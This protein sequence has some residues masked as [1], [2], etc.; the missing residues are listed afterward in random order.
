MS[1]KTKDFLLKKSILDVFSDLLYFPYISE[2][3]KAF[4]SAIIQKPEP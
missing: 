2:I 3:I 1:Q 4:I